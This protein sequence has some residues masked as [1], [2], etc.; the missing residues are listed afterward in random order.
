[1]KL[2]KIGQGKMAGLNG[3]V[4]PGGT[5]GRVKKEEEMSMTG[6]DLKKI[7]AA[8][9][10]I[11]HAG[12]LFAGSGW[13]YWLCRFVGRI[14]FPIYCFLLAEGFIHTKSR[15]KYGQSLLLFALVSEIPFDLTFWGEVLEFG[16]QNVYV[17]LFLGVCMLGAL[18]RLSGKVFL[19][20]GA[21]V[22]F[23]AAAEVLRC[24]YGGVGLLLIAA[25]YYW[26]MGV[27]A[28]PAPLGIAAWES[29][30]CLG[31]G[32]LS[33][34]FIRLYQGERG[35]IRYKYF[36]YWFYPLHLLGLF[37]ISCLVRG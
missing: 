13:L 18:E 15:K 4:K 7:A 23:F 28:W 21:A 8:S 1:M 26:R 10:L 32:A 22:L 11:D 25:F 29:L 6:A 33:F 2:G 19:Q 31:S 36:W 17:T 35:K 24:D 27:L 12:A 9:M 16:Y 20:T 3:P 34:L 37:F 14:A 30:P 5:A